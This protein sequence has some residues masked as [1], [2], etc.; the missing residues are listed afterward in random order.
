[1]PNENDR[2]NDI[3]GGISYLSVFFAPVLFPLIV[4]IVA[5]PPASTHARNALFNHIM[6]WVMVVLGLVTLSISPAFVNSERGIGWI[7]A[8]LIAVL[9]FIW[10]LVL[11]LKNIIRGIKLMMP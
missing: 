5:Q 10:A 11:F 6:S 8:I 9:F 1:M 3:L 4:W 2:E 7:I